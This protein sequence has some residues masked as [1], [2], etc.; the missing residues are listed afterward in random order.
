[1]LNRKKIWALPALLAIVTASAACEQDNPAGVITEPGEP[2]FAAIDTTFSNN[3]NRR[4]AQVER[5]GNPLVMEVFVNK[6]EHDAYDAFPAIQDPNHF[7]DDIVH[8]ITTVAG[9]ERSLAEAVAGVLVGQVNN[10]PGDM[11]KVHLNRAPGV[12]ATTAQSSPNVGWLSQVTAGANGY[13]GRMIGDDAVDIGTAVVF[14]AALSPNNT[15]PGLVSDNV[16]S[17][18]PRL[19]S[20]FPYF[21]ANSQ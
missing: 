11:I 19:M 9:R 3:P 12:T 10:H 20:T 2:E 14:G 15:S 5:L 17:T 16:S 6:R 13:G 8:F 7:T 21:P 1:M 18:N 4:F